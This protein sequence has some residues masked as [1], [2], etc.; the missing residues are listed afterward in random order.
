VFV[1]KTSTGQEFLEGFEQNIE[2]QEQA[3]RRAAKERP[4]I[5]QHG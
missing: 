4:F 3:P 1:A 2:Q 5:L